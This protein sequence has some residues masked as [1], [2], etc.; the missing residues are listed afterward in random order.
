MIGY[1]AVAE[2]EVFRMPKEHVK[3]WLL[4]QLSYFY[5]FAFLIEAKKTAL[6]WNIL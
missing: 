3:F 1:E 5:Q 2:I 4:S 6:F